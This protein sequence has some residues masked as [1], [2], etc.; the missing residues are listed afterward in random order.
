MP[1]SWQD[2]TDGLRSCLMITRQS[3]AASRLTCLRHR[4][5][6]RWWCLKSNET[7]HRRRLRPAGRLLSPAG[8]GQNEVLARL[9]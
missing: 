8:W 2:R 1:L 3:T 6:G 9:H 7:G 4:S 5:S